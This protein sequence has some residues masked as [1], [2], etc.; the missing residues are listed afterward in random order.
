MS[1]RKKFSVDALLSPSFAKTL[2]GDADVASGVA[3]PQDIFKIDVNA[4]LAD[5]AGLQTDVVNKPKE[6]APAA[7]QP[8]N[9]NTTNARVQRDV[10]G[11]KQNPLHAADLRRRQ[12]TATAARF[13][14]TKH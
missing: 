14:F 11:V 13:G 1:D 2:D 4:N 12:T 9:E 7:L 3:F 6:R 10:L 5:F 8:L